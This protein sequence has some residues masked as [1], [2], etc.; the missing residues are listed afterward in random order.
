[1]QRQPPAD[2]PAD[3][4]LAQARVR[5][6]EWQSR[7]AARGRALRPPPPEPQGCCGRGC[8]GCVWEGW[9]AALGWWEEDASA[10][11]AAGPAPPR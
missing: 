9:Y 8:S 5:I 4:P 3:T 7:L 6:A 1:M 2:P 11:V 10:L